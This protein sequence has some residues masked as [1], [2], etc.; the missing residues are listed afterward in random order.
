MAKDNFLESVELRAN[1]QAG[2]E[3]ANGRVCAC[4]HHSPGRDGA[5]K[6]A[7]YVTDHEKIVRLSYL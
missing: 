3:Q 7:P 1:V 2:R 6:H 4:T 5:C